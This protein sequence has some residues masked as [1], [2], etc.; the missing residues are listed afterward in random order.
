MAS[1]DPGVRDQLAVDRT[2][3]ANERTLLAYERT[4]LGSA[5]AGLAL[6]HV[7]SATADHAIGWVLVAIGVILAPIGVYRYARVASRLRD[8]PSS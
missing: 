5:A 2:R 7:F 4:S 1:G 3:L 6:I 8:R